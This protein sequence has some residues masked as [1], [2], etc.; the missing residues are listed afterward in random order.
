MYPE[1][2]GVAP[3]STTF[4]AQSRR[5]WKPWL[6]AFVALCLTACG[7]GGG[8]GS[9]PAPG[10]STSGTDAAA[11][12]VVKQGRFI[13]SPVIGVY[14]ETATHKGYTGLNGDFLYREGESVTFS[15]GKVVFPMVPASA[16]VTPL[17]LAG[18]DLKDPKVANMAYFLQSLDVDGN[19]ANGLVIDKRLLDTTQEIKVPDLNNSTGLGPTGLACTKVD[20]SNILSFS[21]PLL[22]LCYAMVKLSEITI[23]FNQETGDFVRDPMVKNLLLA[24]QQLTGVEVAIT[25]EAA[26]EDL[27]KNLLAEKESPS[28]LGS[29]DSDTK[30]STTCASQTATM[31]GSRTA[32]PGN[33]WADVY[34]KPNNKYGWFYDSTFANRSGS[35]LGDFALS[36]TSPGKPEYIA[37]SLSEY[38]DASYSPAADLWLRHRQHEG[39]MLRIAAR[40]SPG[41]SKT[42]PGYA[43]VAMYLHYVGL[44][45][46]YLELMFGPQ[47]APTVFFSFIGNEA[48]L[49]YTGTAGRDGVMN[50]GDD[51]YYPNVA[52][53]GWH[54]HQPGDKNFP[55]SLRMGG[56]SP[57]GRQL[58][59]GTCW[60]K[61]GGSILLWTRPSNRVDLFFSPIS[62]VNKWGWMAPYYD[63]ALGFDGS[64][65]IREGGS[66]LN[67]ISGVIS[68]Q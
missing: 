55:V 2:P 17:T 53:E 60:I 49:Q 9:P 13:D 66:R 37:A 64:V 46:S 38:W 20:S 40:K 15:I 43:G 1:K 57:N 45:G 42:M 36:K 62:A 30:P 5:F 27:A 68:G 26:V 25:P 52:G 51:G 61:S 35:P 50:T 33:L 48:S 54:N 67:I 39:V 4:A 63:D 21:D 65:G 47:Q 10:V 16:L 11:A 8:G 28:K 59:V 34:A 12:N 41:E 6:N 7:G 32:L 56:T 31:S 18:A 58:P 24:N 22:N 19:T 44:P 29:L 3:M 23:N 14:Y